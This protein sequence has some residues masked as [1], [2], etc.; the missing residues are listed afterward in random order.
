MSKLQGT[1]ADRIADYFVTYLFNQY[2]GSRH[3]RRVAA[4]I[5][6]IVLGI[7]RSTGTN[8]KVS[9]TR[10]LQFEFHS[11]TFKIRYNHQIGN[12]G[13]L[14]IV[15]VLPGRGSPEGKT[16]AS[17]TDLDEAEKFYNKAPL[18]FSKYAPRS[19]SA[20]VGKG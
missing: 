2:T 7:Q 20:V 8:W 4:W 18:L 9:R 11:Q 13:G 5:G 15:E 19:D 1:S 3:V 16:L 17:I 14:E 10:Q 12:R 6:L